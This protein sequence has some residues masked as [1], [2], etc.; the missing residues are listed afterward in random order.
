MTLAEH[1]VKEIITK[2]IK[3][4]DYRIE[5]VNLID[6]EFLQFAMDFLKKIANAKSASKDITID[7]YRKAFTD[8]RLPPDSIAINSGMN[9][10]TIQNMYGTTRKAVVIEASE[11]HFNS[12]YDNIMT[13]TDLEKGTDVNMRIR[14]HETDISLSLPESV[15]VLNT[16]AVKRAALRGAIWSTAGKRVEKHLMLTL[17][18]LYQVPREY[19][20]ASVFKKGK[21]KKVNREVDF[22]LLSNGNRYKCEV[23]LMGKGNPESADAVIA[24]DSKVFVADTL[25]KQNKNQCDQLGISWV[26]LKST[27]GYRRFKEVL[28]KLE[29]PHIDYT[30]NLDEDLPDILN[31]LFQPQMPEL[32]L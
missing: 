7:W 19:F 30:G 27:D 31:R 4:Q 22:Y 23:K 21:K 10:K 6:A 12:L 14:F 32:P 3:S 9:T 17:C 18:K 1:I 13:L 28:E 5:I 26:E 24:R 8:K 20:D 25:S 2:V 11:K 16:L 15:M 29:I